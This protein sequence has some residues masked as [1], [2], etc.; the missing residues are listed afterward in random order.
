[1]G[2]DFGYPGERLGLP[3]TGPGS[4]APV[5]RRIAALFVDWGLCVLIAYGLLARGDLGA[6]NMWTSAVFFVAS[7]LFIGTLGFTPGKRLLRL[8][9]VRADG[10]RL[11]VLA[12]MLRTFLL[13]LVIPAVVW[14]RDYRGLHDKAVRAVQVRF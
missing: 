8:R 5:G 13:L 4:I 11:S 9:L 12:A 10:E 7:V 14:D 2:A 3:R 1:M 6:T